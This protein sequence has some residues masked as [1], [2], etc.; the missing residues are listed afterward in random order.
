MPLS[1]LTAVRTFPIRDA[2]HRRPTVMCGPLFIRPP[3]RAR[4]IAP[5]LPL[6]RLIKRFPLGSSPMRPRTPIESERFQVAP[7]IC[8]NSVSS[9]IRCRLSF[10]YSEFLLPGSGRPAQHRIGVFLLTLRSRAPRAA[11]SIFPVL[12]PASSRHVPVIEKIASHGATPPLF[13]CRNFSLFQLNLQL[14]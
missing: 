14:L 9:R 4:L 6:R 3:A 7:N 12:L 8:R 2:R 13:L 10:P 1:F 11:L 5:H